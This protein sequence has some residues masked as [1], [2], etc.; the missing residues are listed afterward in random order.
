MGVTGIEPNDLIASAGGPIP[1][2]LQRNSSINQIFSNMPQRM[3]KMIQD[4]WDIMGKVKM[5]DIKNA[6]KKIL[7]KVKIL[8]AEGK[9]SL[10]SD[11]EEYV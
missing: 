3:V 10:Q 5:K 9:I 8:I 7:E 1:Q 2:L 6:Q 4:E 11:N